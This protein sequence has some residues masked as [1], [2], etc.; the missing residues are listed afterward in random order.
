[1]KKQILL[2]ALIC[3]S[4]ATFAT[5]YKKGIITADKVN[6]RVKP[7]TDTV[8]YTPVVTLLKDSIILILDEKGDWY[9]IIA[10]KK[11]AAWVHKNFVSEDNIITR[12]I[13]LR[14]G[15]ELSF[16]AYGIIKKGTKVIINKKKERKDWYAIQPPKGTVAWISKKFVKIEKENTPEKQ[17]EKDIPIGIAQK[18]LENLTKT[19]IPLDKATLNDI[20]T[21]KNVVLPFEKDFAYENAYQGEIVPL[22][23]NSVYVTHSLIVKV[24]D[25]N[26]PTCFLHSNRLDLSKWNY[27]KVIVKGI[28]KRVN[29]WKRVVLEVSEIINY[30]PDTNIKKEN[31]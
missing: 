5:E 20:K 15:P 16:T 23:S 1:M 21:G 2:L 4:I 24:N 27:K 19:D 9:K 7:S 14:S 30:E 29:K 26:Y 12:D 18:A 13:N 6:V 25:D 8:F 17:V 3:F 28:V 10:P 22:N 11:S 31:K